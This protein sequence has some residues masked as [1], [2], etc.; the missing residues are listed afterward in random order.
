MTTQIF[1]PFFLSFVL[2]CAKTTQPAADD[3]TNGLI[4]PTGNMQTARAGH[5]ATVL[6]NGKVLIAGGFAAST[7]SSAEIYDTAL[8]T[9]TYVG[10]MSVARLA[11]SATLLPNGQVLI[12]GGYNGNY[13]S[14]TEIFDPQTQTFSPGPIM[15]TPRSEHTATVLNNGKILFAG[16]VGVGWSFLQSAELYDIQSK[17]FTPTGSMTTARDSHTATLLENEN[18]LITGGH[19]DRRA[20]IKIYSSAE[21]YDPVS[22]T[23]KII[24]NMSVIRHKHDAVGLA[25]G[26]ILINGGSDE[27]DSRGVYKSAELYDPISSSF[28]PAGEMNITRYKHNGTSILLPNGNVLIAGGA[29][30][31]EIYQPASGKF[32]IIYGSMGTDRLFT[33]ATLL[34]NGQVLITGGYNE[35]LEFSASSWLYIYE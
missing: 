23:F 11:H 34:Q 32:S 8:K 10:E 19:R 20:N 33:R 15:N 28:K 17:T 9:F 5:T 31:A 7:I 6:R 35:N 13:L 26:R 3:T 4:I 14:S 29:N 21:L 12:A 24:G 30:L 27:R 25:D 18:V 16:G 1:I 22:E 2:S